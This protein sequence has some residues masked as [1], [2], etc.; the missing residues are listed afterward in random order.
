MFEKQLVELGYTTQE[1]ILERNEKVKWEE[2]SDIFP[3][4]K[5]LHKKTNNE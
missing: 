2:D 3:N 4:E 5:Y 1:E